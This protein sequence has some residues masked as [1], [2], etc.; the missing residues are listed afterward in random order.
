ML[1]TL[2]FCPYATQRQPFTPALSSLQFSVSRPSALTTSALIS[3]SSSI[4]FVVVADLVINISLLTK[5][6]IIIF[7]DKDLI[8][9]RFPG[10]L[11]NGSL[12]DEA[13]SNF[14]QFREE[15]KD[16]GLRGCNLEEIMNEVLYNNPK[17]LLKHRWEF[18]DSY[19]HDDLAYSRYHH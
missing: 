3:Q 17:L 15:S 11:A 13:Y 1:K 10:L 16:L 2:S 7:S 9:Q 8:G 19:T 6:F 5:H 14:L 12:T 18:K 4:H